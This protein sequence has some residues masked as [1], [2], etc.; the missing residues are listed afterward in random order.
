MAFI[1]DF[2]AKTGTQLCFVFKISVTDES[3]HAYFNILER[4]GTAARGKLLAS[5]VHRY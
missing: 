1:S 4:G 2:N 5:A 3:H